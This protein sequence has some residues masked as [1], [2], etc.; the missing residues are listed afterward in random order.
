MAIG[1]APVSG[2][3]VYGW[4]SWRYM[5]AATA[6]GL[7]G[8][9]IGW[10]LLFLLFSVLAGRPS[11]PVIAS[12]AGYVPIYVIFFPVFS[13]L[14][15]RSRPPGL[16]FGSE[17]IELAAERRDVLVVPYE[18]VSRARVRW[19]WPVAVLD[20]FVSS[21]DELRVRRLDRDGRRP[22]RRRKDDQLRFS[23]P[24]AGLRS[25]PADIRSELRRR[26]LAE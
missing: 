7:L 23:M 24:I 6:I 20:L 16:R 17:G 19:F 11:N 3:V 15:T 13:L 18:V 22:L 1:K 10:P 26:G 12:A 5:V 14:L 9:G 2:D 4:S 25:S 8:A 21:A